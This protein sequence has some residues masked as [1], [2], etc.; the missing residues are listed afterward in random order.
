MENKKR[1]IQISKRHSSD[2]KRENQ[3]HSRG[4]S[5]AFKR[6]F[7]QANFST[8]FKSSCKELRVA[9][10]RALGHIENGTAIHENRLNPKNFLSNNDPARVCL[11]GGNEDSPRDSIL[12]SSRIKL[13]R[14]GCVDVKGV[15]PFKG[16]N[17]RA[18][19]N[20][21]GRRSELLL[22][23]RLAG[24]AK[25]SENLAQDECRG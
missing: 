5:S 19:P 25:L 8:S 20:E 10:S 24:C 16:L 6:E 9:A 4:H 15:L 23:R 13:V 11:S 17:E 18:W 21:L 14:W 7:S 22:G 1:E 12:R 2:L 3:E